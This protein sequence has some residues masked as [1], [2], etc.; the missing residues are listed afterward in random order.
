M[1]TRHAFAAALAALVLAEL[2][3]DNGVQWGVTRNYAETKAKDC[4]ASLRA[5]AWHAQTEKALKN[6]P[7][8]KAAER[9]RLPL[10]AL[11]RFVG[12]QRFIQARD[13]ASFA[14]LAGSDWRPTAAG[15]LDLWRN[16][17]PDNL[18]GLFGTLLKGELAAAP[19]LQR[20]IHATG[21]D[22]DA[23]GR[24]E[25]GT[26][27]APEP[28]AQAYGAYWALLARD[29][30]HAAAAA[31][32]AVNFPAWGDACRRVLHG[33]R[34]DDKMAVE[35]KKRGLAE[36]QEGLAFLAF[37]AEP[38]PNLEEM[39]LSILADDFEKNGAC[40]LIQDD[41]RTLQAYEVDFWDAVWKPS[42]HASRGE[43]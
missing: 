32:A 15:L 28:R 10:Q 25:D 38:L 34:K 14:Q 40:E 33:L 36:Y 19:L 11:Q 7:F 6:H 29:G 27:F 41:V 9:G 31:A 20:L 30:K 42:H 12:E 21:L 37:F 24:S 43:L 3:D 39:A 8:V 16:T 23:H 1:R 4:L 17:P 18:K 13:A 35:L 5:T 22:Y 26:F 2:V